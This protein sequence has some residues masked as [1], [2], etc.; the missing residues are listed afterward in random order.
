MNRWSHK[1]CRWSSRLAQFST[2]NLIITDQDVY[3]RVS[4]IIREKVFQT[5]YE[6]VPHHTYVEVE[7]MEDKKEN[8]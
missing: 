6:E 2:L 3:T 5:T 1:S 7:T 4:E 8:S